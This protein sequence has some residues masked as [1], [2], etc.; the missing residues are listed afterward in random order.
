MKLY[1]V[2]I[3]KNFFSN[4]DFV[5]KISSSGKQKG[6]G[7]ARHNFGPSSGRQFN[8]GSSALGSTTMA[9]CVYQLTEDGRGTGGSWGGRFSSCE[10][11]GY[12]DSLYKPWYNIVPFI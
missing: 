1:R 11:G 9:M 8:F 3:Y 6:A 10:E 7:A 2:T 4:H 5:Y 12:K